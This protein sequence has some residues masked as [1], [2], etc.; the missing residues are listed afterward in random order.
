[1]LFAQKH[2]WVMC[3]WEY[4]KSYGGAA[5]QMLTFGTKMYRSIRK[6]QV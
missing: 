6:M 1:M 3:K 5:S 4:T 2:T